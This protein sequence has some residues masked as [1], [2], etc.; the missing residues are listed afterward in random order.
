MSVR[1]RKREETISEIDSQPLSEIELHELEDVMERHK[2]L[3][4]INYGYGVFST[5][6][7]PRLL[8]TIHE[9]QRERDQR[10]KER[11]DALGLLRNVTG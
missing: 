5:L 1:A 7:I 2:S 3:R 9:L 11:D 8:A 10:C 6:C 4:E